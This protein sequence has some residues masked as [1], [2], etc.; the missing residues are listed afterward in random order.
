M[1]CKKDPRAGDLLRPFRCLAKEGAMQVPDE[2]GNINKLGEGDR[3]YR[4]MR[5]YLDF[6][7]FDQLLYILGGF[8]SG[9]YFGECLVVTVW[10]LPNIVFAGN[11]RLNYSTSSLR[12]I[13]IRIEGAL[14]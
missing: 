11:T 14:L 13:E 12:R 4:E 1:G 5:A 6:G 10:I 8:F 7:L 9:D 2:K 3:R